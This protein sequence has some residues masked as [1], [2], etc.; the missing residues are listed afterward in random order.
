MVVFSR[1]DL[2]G[3]RVRPSPVS[4][5]RIHSNIVYPGI[6][7]ASGQ[8]EALSAQHQN[9]LTSSKLRITHKAFVKIP[10]TLLRFGPVCKPTVA[11]VRYLCLRN[12]TI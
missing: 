8:S 5:L 12:H 6:R 4:A 7:I 3:D 1:A 10:N 2:L 9:T 11:N